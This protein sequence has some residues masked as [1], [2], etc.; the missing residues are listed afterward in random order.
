MRI[1]AIKKTHYKNS[2]SLSFSELDSLLSG[3]LKIETVININTGEKIENPDMK[4]IKNTLRPV[5]PNG[6]KKG[7]KGFCYVGYFRK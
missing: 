5:T 3:D 7:P 2:V 1:V 6:K 4:M